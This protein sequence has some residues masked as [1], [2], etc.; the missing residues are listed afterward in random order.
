MMLRTACLSV[1]LL[2]TLQQH[3]KC[4]VKEKRSACK[5][6]PKARAPATY[7][8]LS[9]IHKVTGGLSVGTSFQSHRSN[10]RR[11]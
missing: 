8:E 10:L 7:L 2:G 3:A 5:L 6:K 11:P 9:Q 1:G 4:K